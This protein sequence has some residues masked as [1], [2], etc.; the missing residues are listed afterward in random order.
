MVTLYAELKCLTIEFIWIDIVAVIG[1]EHAI[2]QLLVVK[3]YKKIY[4]QDNRY[5]LDTRDTCAYQ[6]NKTE[7]ENLEYEEENGEPIIEVIYQ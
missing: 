1:Q 3:I 6:M 7:Q 4:L 2:M 5:Y